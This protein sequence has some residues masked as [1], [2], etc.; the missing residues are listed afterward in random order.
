MKYLALVL[1][2]IFMISCSPSESNSGS[3]KS[4][5]PKQTTNTEAQKPK[6]KPTTDSSIPASE[7]VELDNKGVGPITSVELDDEVNKDLAAE[8]EK[9]FNQYC[10]LCHKTEEKYIG[11][12][13]TGIL[14][15]RSPE[16]VMN[17]ILKP[18]LMVMKDPLAKDLLKE[19]N[20]SPMSNQNISEDQARAML[21]YFRT[22]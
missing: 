17:M 9:L 3:S 8:G 11:P 6:P 22:L 10:T 13:L 14:D 12:A 19:Y 7:R 1:C 2:T 5:Q 4:E 21:E 16:W 18:E 20:N 15:R